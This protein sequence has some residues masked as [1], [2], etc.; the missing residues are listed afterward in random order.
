MKIYRW[1]K[2]EAKKQGNLDYGFIKSLAE[3]KLKEIQGES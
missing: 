1:A 2:K 3:A